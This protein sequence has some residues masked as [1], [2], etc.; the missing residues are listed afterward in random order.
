MNEEEPGNLLCNHV[1]ISEEDE[2]IEEDLELGLAA[3]EQD[4]E[5]IWYFDS[6]C[7]RHMTGNDDLL[8]N[9]VQTTVKR[10]MFGTGK[11]VRVQLNI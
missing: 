4:R 1:M 2:E 8:T 6:G 7:S 10:V 11:K 9:L 5:G 3:N